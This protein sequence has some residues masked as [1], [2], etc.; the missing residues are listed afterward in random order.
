MI[1]SNSID[2]GPMGPDR[3]GW[4]PVRALVKVCYSGKY[5]RDELDRHVF[6]DGGL[7]AYLG[8]RT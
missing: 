4:L 7:F 3:S 1:D 5:T 8:T 2:E 6:G